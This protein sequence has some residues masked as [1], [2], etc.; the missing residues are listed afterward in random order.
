M[1]QKWFAGVR[2]V[3]HARKYH[4]NIWERCSVLSVCLCSV[5]IVGIFNG[6]SRRKG[7][8]NEMVLREGHRASLLTGLGERRSLA[9]PRDRFAWKLWS[10]LLHNSAGLSWHLTLFYA[11]LWSDH[12]WILTPSPASATPLIRHAISDKSAKMAEHKAT[13]EKSAGQHVDL[14]LTRLPAI[15]LELKYV[16]V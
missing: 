8:L 9:G 5:G 6:C 11:G 2:V 15:C 14:L 7:Y 12:Q 16:Y 13:T 10:T 3:P 4:Y 1:R